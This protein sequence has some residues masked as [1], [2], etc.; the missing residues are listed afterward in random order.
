MNNLRITLFIVLNMIIPTRHDV[1]LRE[2]KDLVKKFIEENLPKIDKSGNVEKAFNEF[3]SSE[4]A[5][6]LKTIAKNENIPIDK[7]EQLVGEY[8]YTQRMPRGQDIVDLLPKTPKILERQGIINRIKSA[9]E[10]I[11]EKFEW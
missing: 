11:V 5:G 10:N 9:I 6:S 3:W 7:I 4:R 2:K 8:L 1:Q